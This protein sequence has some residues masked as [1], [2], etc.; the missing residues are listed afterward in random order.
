M[1]DTTL[2]KEKLA[3]DFRAVM[4]DIDSL[5]T[6]TGNQAEGEVKALRARI[7]ERLDGAK[8][9]LLDAQHEAVERAKAAATATDNYVH[10]KPWQAIGVTAAVALAVGVLIGRR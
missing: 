1:S 7:R 5:M 10:E 3:A 8:D 2:A 4:D 9:R 6:A